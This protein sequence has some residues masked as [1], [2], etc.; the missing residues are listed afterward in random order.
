MPQ[1]VVIAPVLRKLIRLLHR[2]QS[3]PSS[4]EF[5]LD[6]GFSFYHSNISML[7][8]NPYQALQLRLSRGKKGEN[9]LKPGNI[10]TLLTNILSF[11]GGG[12]GNKIFEFTELT[13]L[14][15]GKVLAVEKE[16]RVG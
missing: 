16:G 15:I 2:D 4:R 3:L 13:V 1:I 11:N 14:E 6:H 8:H 12:G 7:L 10:Y 9:E 5:D